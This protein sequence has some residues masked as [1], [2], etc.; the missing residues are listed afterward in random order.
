MLAGRKYRLEFDFGQRVFAER[1]GGICRAVWNTGLEQRR[2]YRRRGAYLSYEEQ[3]AQLAEAKKDPYCDWF[4][5]APAQV[6][7]QTLKDL[8]KACRKH[9][10]WKVRWKSRTRWRPSFRF[11]TAKHT[12][13]ERINRR[14]GRV[15][16]PK[17][18]W[19]RFRMSRPLGG[20]VKS[21]TVSRDG[22]HWFISFLVED[23]LAQVD[24]HVHPGAH[25]GVDRG[26]VTAAVTSDG[27]FFDR[28]HAGTGSVSSLV[29]PSERKGDRQRD[30]GFLAAGEAE[31][32]LRLQ[33]RLARSKKGSGRRRQVVAAMGAIMR[34]VRWRRA[35]LHAQA[36]HRLTRRYGVVVLEDLNIGGMTAA[37]RPRPD[38]DQVGRWLRNGAAAKSGLN[39]AILDKGWYGLESALRSKARYTGTV[40][41]KVPAAYTSQTC[42]APACGTVDDKSRESQA[43]FSCTACGHAEHADIVGAK[44]TLARYRAAGLVVPG[45]GDPSGSEKRQAPRSTARAAQ[46]ARAAA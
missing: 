35:D 37:V 6:I 3:C 10:T 12:P 4:A 41:V 9:G 11:P 20:V 26:V 8:D 33:R 16:L 24:Q 31:R 7:Q 25:A 43:V 18:G 38:P 21:A 45:R 46:A 22:R 27:E 42:P 14:W 17:F 5:D 36:A 44:N 23:G 30:L 28:R 19:V 15:F 32:Y 1:L 34:R 13:V 39:R 2:E 29:P 40:V